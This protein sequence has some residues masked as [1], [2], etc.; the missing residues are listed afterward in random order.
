[1]PNR[2]HLFL[3]PYRKVS[4]AGRLNGRFEPFRHG[5]TADFCG[6]CFEREKTGTASEISNKLLKMSLCFPS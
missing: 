5:D 3:R 6:S 4:G 1:M 2:K